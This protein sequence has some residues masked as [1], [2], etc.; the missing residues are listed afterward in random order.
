MSG[1]MFGLTKSLTRAVGTA[2]A[3][4]LF[5]TMVG[6][7]V[8]AQSEPLRVVTTFSIL[9][10]LVRN[11]GGDRVQITTLVGANG[12]AHA[13]EPSPV[14]AATLVE[15]DAIFEIGLEFETWLEDLYTSSGS[16]A[17]RIV[18]SDGIEL[19]EAGGHSDEHADEHGDHAEATP[20]GTEEAHD[21]HAEGTPEGDEHSDEHSDEHGEYDPHVWHDPRN[22]EV[23]VENILAALIE[24]DPDGRSVYEANAAQ[25]VSE[26]R[27]LDATLEALLADVPEGNRK[28]V[29]THDTFG[30]FAKRYGFEIVATALGLTTEVADPS[31]AQIV[32]LVEEI[33]ESGVPAI[34]T[35]NIGS[36]GIL[37]QVAR[38]AGVAVVPSLYTDALGE[39]GSE[40]GTYIDMMT[41][42][43][44]T[45]ADAL[46]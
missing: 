42:N 22:A 7:P 29:T 43:A 8:R 3:I 10:D 45:I 28:L 44:T 38:E 39:A 41:Y 4:A 16:S 17:V 12:D 20:E 23:M 36:N 25:Y 9:E 26:L 27:E 24:L 21:D 18:V 5:S 15:A 30:Y 32:E 19:I 35:E 46:K 34:F 13:F 33:K 40:G 1:L 11:V 37:E 14:D 2:S 31:A 6:T